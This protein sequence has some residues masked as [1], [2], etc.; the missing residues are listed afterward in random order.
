VSDAR[1]TVVVG[2]GPYGLSLAAFLLAKHVP[3]RVFGSAMA[4]WEREMPRGMQLK[5]EPFASSIA[6][7]KRELT[8]ER[9]YRE[10]DLDYRPI[11]DPVP[12]ERFVAY[13][14]WFRERAAVPVE[15]QHVSRISA[16]PAG[17][18]VELQGG[19]RVAAARVV[20]ATGAAAF[21]HVPGELDGLPAELVSHVSRHDDLARFDG[22]RVAVLGAGQ[23]ALET[24]T[25]LAENGAAPVLVARTTALRWNGP[26]PTTRRFRSKLR[27]PNTPLGQGWP[28]AGY[29]VGPG[30]F[31]RRPLATRAQVV[32]A[33]LGPAGAWWLRERFEG[34]VDA[35]LGTRVIAAEKRDG[36]VTLRLR[37]GE[38]EETVEVDHVIAATGY[39]VDLDRLQL[40]APDLRRA[41]R[42]AH[43]A[44]LLS[45]RFE[46][47][48]P[49]LSFV[50]LP[51]ALSFGPLLRFVCGTRFTSR[52]VAAHAGRR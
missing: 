44:P 5:S 24:A 8:L 4:A 50:G 11:G 35:R 51:A 2:A 12:C 23:S 33:A 10:H 16:S 47:S 25:L 15:D 14:R 39:R 48:V 20:V 34:R 30:L 21:A 32:R 17:F 43:G 3:I 41:V 27:S 37:S 18:D 28:T 49:G 45:S 26:P 42:T 38:G 52:R 40:L 19:E 1:P 46:S 31:R 29:V 6:D 7:P 22:R 9:Y 13:G 36:G